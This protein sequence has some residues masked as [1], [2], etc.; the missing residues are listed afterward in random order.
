MLPGIDPRRQRNRYGRGL[1]AGQESGVG[2]I[3]SG[4]SELAEHNG[5]RVR[6]ID[7]PNGCDTP[8]YSFEDINPLM[9]DPDL[10][11][12]ALEHPARIW[13]SLIHSL[14]P[15]LQPVVKWTYEEVSMEV[16]GQLV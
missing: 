10:P 9:C 14:P 15:E 1:V 2:V 12:L 16:Q 6:I 5:V 13:N 7:G 3:G 4:L 8:A 11:P